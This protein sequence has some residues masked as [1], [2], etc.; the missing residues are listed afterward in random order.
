LFDTGVIKPKKDS[1]HNFQV[2]IQ[3]KMTFDKPLTF[4]EAISEIENTVLYEGNGGIE[5]ES[6][7]VPGS[8]LTIFLFSKYWLSSAEFYL[9]CK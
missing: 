4:T 8:N 6:F 2:E 1:V 9:Q 5:Y 3:G 7:D